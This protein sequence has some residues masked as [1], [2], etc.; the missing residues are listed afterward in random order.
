MRRIRAFLGPILLA[1]G[2]VPGT[3]FGAGWGLVGAD[4]NFWAQEGSGV[5]RSDA[6]GTPGSLIDLERSLG[7]DTDVELP[8]GRV[9]LGAAGV[10]FVVSYYDSE[11]A[12][13]AVLQ[14]NLTFNGQT[15]T[16]GETVDSRVETSV[17]GVYYF[18]SL[19]PVPRVDFGFQVG[20][21]IV[22]LFA[23]MESTTSG[24]ESVDE[25]LPLPVA[26]LHF[27]IQPVPQLRI[28]ADLSGMS[29]TVD[30][31]DYDLLDGRAQLEWRFRRVAGVHAGYRWFDV[32]VESDSLGRLDSRQ[33][34]PFIGMNVRF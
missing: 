13:P 16:S 25:T 6:G 34:G 11:Y 30:G 14:E 19:L 5:L 27:G 2:T 29:A 26:G 3:A 7:L 21:D 22:D 8:D 31:S 32:Q 20:V 1:A 23:V 17:V 18:Q 12:G 33:A 24:R 15:F 10:R 28:Y 4:L 9:W